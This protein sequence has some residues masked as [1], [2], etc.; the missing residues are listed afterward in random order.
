MDIINIIYADE[1]NNFFTGN[2]FNRVY[3]GLKDLNNNTKD[4][5]HEIIRSN[6][7]SF[8]IFGFHEKTRD[9]EIEEHVYLGIKSNAKLMISEFFIGISLY[10]SNAEKIGEKILKL[11]P[12]EKTENL[13]D[14]V[15]F[16]E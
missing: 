16:K 5:I 12:E 7:Y 4:K 10:G 15:I 14:K 6:I 1:C 2:Y 3:L 8:R 9:N 13:S 11:L